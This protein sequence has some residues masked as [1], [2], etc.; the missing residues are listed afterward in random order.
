MTAAEAFFLSPAKRGLDGDSAAARQTLA[1]IEEARAKRLLKNDADRIRVL[2]FSI[3]TPGSVTSAIEPLRIARK[4]DRYGSTARGVLEPWIVE[5]ALARLG[6]RQLTPEEQRVVLKVTRT[7]RKVKWPEW[8]TEL[9]AWKG[10]PVPDLGA[11]LGLMRSAVTAVLPRMSEQDIAA[12]GIKVRDG[13]KVDSSMVQRPSAEHSGTE[14]DPNPDRD[15][16]AAA[17]SGASILFGD[18]DQPYTI[19]VDDV[20]R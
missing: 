19:H 20:R 5:A 2:V 12:L 3:V 10:S 17:K 7:P 9:P 18:A 15:L 13:R 11:P 14:A 4:L 8:W 1:T 6:E 16:R